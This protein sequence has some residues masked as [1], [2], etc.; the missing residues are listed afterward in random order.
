VNDAVLT[1]LSSFI[2]ASY[3]GLPSCAIKKNFT[4]YSSIT[5]AKRGG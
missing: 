1:L 2:K 5:N 3:R 4:N